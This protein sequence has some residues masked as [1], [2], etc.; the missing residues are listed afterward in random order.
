MAVQCGDAGEQKA[1]RDRL[2]HDAIGSQPIGAGLHGGGGIGRDGDDTGANT[3]GSEQRGGGER[4]FDQRNGGGKAG[5]R[6]GRLGMVRGKAG[7]AQGSVKRAG[8][9]PPHPLVDRRIGLQPGLILLAVDPAVDAIG[10]GRRALAQR[11]H[12]AGEA[13]QRRG[14]A[15]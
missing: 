3:H 6:I 14:D 15:P 11:P 4:E 12:Q 9:R 2:G 10:C 8:K 1:G 5:G 7:T 13:P